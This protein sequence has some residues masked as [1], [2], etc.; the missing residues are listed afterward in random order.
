MELNNI[1]KINEYLTHKQI[2]T[3]ASYPYL[4]CSTSLDIRGMKIKP[5][6]R[7]IITPVRMGID[8]EI[9]DETVTK[10]GVK[11]GKYKHKEIRKEYI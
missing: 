2:N 10:C 11:R 7:V 9:N 1:T 5:T 6:L 4:K 3:N 8:K